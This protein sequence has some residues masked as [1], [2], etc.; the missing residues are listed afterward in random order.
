[1]PFDLFIWLCYQIILKYDYMFTFF[2]FF[3]LKHCSYLSNNIEKQISY[4]KKNLKNILLKI[5]HTF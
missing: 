3:L 5:F 4:G 1:M 2:F